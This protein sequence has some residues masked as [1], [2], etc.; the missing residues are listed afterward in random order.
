MIGILEKI[1]KIGIL[2]V[3]VIDDA[4][5]AVATVDALS[6]G[7]IDAVEVTFRTDAAEDAIKSIANERPDIILGA[8][9][10]T[11]IDQVK[12]AVASGAKF[13]VTPGYN[14][15]VVNYCVQS[16]VPIVPGVMDTNSIEMAIEAGL[17]VVKFFPAEQ[18][19]G[20]EMLKA[21]SAPYAKLRF[22]PTGGVNKDNMTEYLS[23][24]K[25]LAVGG[26]WMVKR[27]MIAQG[28]FKE[29]KKITEESVNRMLDFRVDV[30]TLKN[31]GKD[32][33]ITVV[34]S[35]IERA[36]YHLAKE[37][38]DLKKINLRK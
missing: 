8:G 38:V 35:N 20:L 36:T 34:T 25:I 18:A 31:I 14:P 33:T 37:G 10:V 28:K 11:S 27:D 32:D 9:T 30:T 26:S 22:I 17:E 7:G 1:Y 2:P 21:L 15:V 4:D 23:F 16:N 24:D 19:G 12:R 29:I 6:G 5:N 13:M 3:V